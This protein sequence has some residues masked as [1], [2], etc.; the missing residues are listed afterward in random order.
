MVMQNWV[1]VEEEFLSISTPGLD[2]AVRHALKVL[3]GME[4]VHRSH[5]LRRALE[6][7]VDTAR[8]DARNVAQ[9]TYTATPKKLFDNMDIAYR[10]HDDGQE[11]ELEFTGAW[12]L[13]RYHF[14][15]L[16]SIPG[17]RPRG[18][19][20]TRV[21]KRG[22]RYAKEL[23]GFDA[24]FI[25]RRRQGDYGLFA[26]VS[27]SGWGSV[28]GS[29][30]QDPKNLWKNSVEMLWGPSPI[31]ALMP[32]MRQQQ[33]IDHAADVFTRQL[34]KEVDALLASLTKG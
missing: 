34:H 8:Q 9:N 33:I 32:R 23:D 20:T 3:A 7:A 12:G 16:P 11:G 25:M 15:P 2:Q 5:A 1:E 17:R 30:R 27:G 18:G 21:L 29:A 22:K 4:Q 26:H 13:H 24:P 6:K 28:R 31:Q 10:S 19:V 14:E